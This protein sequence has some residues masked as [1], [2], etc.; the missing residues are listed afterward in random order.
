MSK[1]SDA[2]NRTVAEYVDALFAR[3]IPAGA[4]RDQLRSS[5]LPPASDTSR[6]GV[7]LS[8][9]DPVASATPAIG[10]A[11]TTARADHTHP[12]NYVCVWEQQTAGTHGGTF[13]S[14]S[15]QTRVLTTEH[16]DTG[17]LASLA[18][19]QVTLA[20][21]VWRTLIVAPASQVGRHQTRLRNITGSAT[22]LV[23]SSTEAP[24]PSIIA[25]RFTLAGGTVIE[26]QHQCQTTRSTDGL[27]VAANFGEIEVYTCAQF[28]RES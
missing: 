8:S 13:T 9:T 15:W 21:G 23:G 27:G 20:A 7:L 18:S 19:N 24:A 26:V 3:G 5:A 6:G 10:T 22:L 1:L 17:G 16:A 14:G 28:W 25:G 12:Q 11:T 4:I 2:I